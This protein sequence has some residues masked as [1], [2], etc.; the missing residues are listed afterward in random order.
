M[1]L[2]FIVHGWIL[3]G[4]VLCVKIDEYE[5]SLNY[6]VPF[7]CFKFFKINFFK[8]IM[9]LNSSDYFHYYHP[10][11]RHQ[12]LSSVLP[13]YCGCSYLPMVHSEHSSQGEPVRTLIR[14]HRSSPQNLPM[15]S[16]LRVKHQSRSRGL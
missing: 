16:R 13:A 3:S 4:Q 12:Q 15:G 8:E 1:Y 11:S 2:F 6:C 5:C 7:L 10:R 14:P 9:N